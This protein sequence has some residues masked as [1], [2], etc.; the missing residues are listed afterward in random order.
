MAI[1]ILDSQSKLR[2]WIDFKIIIKNL[3]KRSGNIKIRFQVE[4]IIFFFSPEL[5]GAFK[6]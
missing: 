6:F 5:L 4:K 1:S 2:S 3:S